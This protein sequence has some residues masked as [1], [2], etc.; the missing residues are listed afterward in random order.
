MTRRKTEDAD[1]RP[2]GDYI[3]ARRSRRGDVKTWGDATMRK[4]RKDRKEPLPNAG[5]IRKVYRALG[6]AGLYSVPYAPRRQTEGFRIATRYTDNRP[7]YAT[8]DTRVDHAME[9]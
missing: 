5:E 4:K 2:G 8:S 3:T 9:N 7:C 6:L 1:A